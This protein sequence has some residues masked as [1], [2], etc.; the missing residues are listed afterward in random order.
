MITSA[1]VKLKVS[2]LS[3]FLKSSAAALELF[4]CKCNDLTDVHAT[5]HGALQRAV[6][7]A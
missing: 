6:A 7:I 5:P 3:L 2:A 1:K 4:F